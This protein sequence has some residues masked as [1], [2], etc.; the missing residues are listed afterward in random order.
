MEPA[1]H[2]L[3]M[4]AEHGDAAEDLV[5]RCLEF[6]QA[7]RGSAVKCKAKGDRY[8]EELAAARASVYEEAADLL[9]RMEPQDAA[10]AMMARAGRLHV[11]T[12]PLMDFD[13]AG[14]QYVKSR[15]WQYCALTINP[16]LEQVA[17]EWE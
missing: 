2:D 4:N 15:A 3:E 9:R 7:A 8:G 17:P 10:P 11:R 6:A 13:R 14:V 1:K 5:D 12:P 16:G